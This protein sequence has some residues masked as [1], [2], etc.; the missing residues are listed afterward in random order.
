[1]S[2]EFVFYCGDV[3][4]MDYYEASIGEESWFQLPTFNA[5]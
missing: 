1:M 4:D 5:Q 2:E 3:M